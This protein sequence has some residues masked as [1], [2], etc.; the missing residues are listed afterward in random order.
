MER[1]RSCALYQQPYMRTLRLGIGSPWQS[2]A[3]RQC[4]GRNERKRFTGAPLTFRY[5]GDD[6]SP[7]T[8]GLSEAQSTFS[9]KNSLSGGI[10]YNKDIVGSF[11]D[12]PKVFYVNGLSTSL[13]RDQNEKHSRYTYSYVKSY[14][15][16]IRG[17]SPIGRLI[18]VYYLVLTPKVLPLFHL[19]FCP[20]RESNY[21]P[22]SPFST[23]VI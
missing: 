4:G 14:D 8:I 11:A 16:R 10:Q 18:S 23:R 21:G 17:S 15:E 12:S 2:E 19:P 22:H 6:R 9:L 3:A 13:T 1:M 20:Q 5:F 7:F